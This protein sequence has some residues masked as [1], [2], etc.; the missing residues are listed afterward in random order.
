M[1]MDGHP[2]SPRRLR[3]LSA[4]ITMAFSMLLLHFHHL[5]WK[6]RNS[7]QKLTYSWAVDLD[8]RGQGPLGVGAQL[9]WDGS[10]FDFE[11]R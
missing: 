5:S 3:T 9:R 11:S 7:N 2:L 8:A 4:A 10:D 6:G 1:R